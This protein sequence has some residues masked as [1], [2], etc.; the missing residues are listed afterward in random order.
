VI[1][2]LDDERKVLIQKAAHGPK[3]PR[4]FEITKP[5]EIEVGKGIVGSVAVNGKAEMH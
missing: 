3:S 2:L 5:I 1:Y 4:Q